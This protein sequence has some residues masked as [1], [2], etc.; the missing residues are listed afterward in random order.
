MTATILVYDEQKFEDAARRYI[1]EGS[2]VLKADRVADV[3]GAKR[4]LQSDA[5]EKLRVKPSQANG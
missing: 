3:D 4:F 2:P 1:E 5:A